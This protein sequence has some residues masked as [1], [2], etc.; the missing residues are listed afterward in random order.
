[1]EWFIKKNATLPT[2]KVKVNKDGR[3]DFE[4]G[5]TDLSESSVFFSM[6]DTETQIPKISSKHGSVISEVNN[7]GETEYYASYQFTKT[8]TNK[9]GRYSAEFMLLNTDGV[10]YLPI[11]EKLFI[12]VTESFS[13][14]DSEFVDNYTIDYS[15]CPETIRPNE[16]I[17]YLSNQDGY[18]LIANQDFL[19][20]TQYI[21]TLNTQ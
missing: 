6:I 14:D 5:D 8:E 20:N 12:N 3:S 4:R 9:E 15:C 11:N 2:L 13:L 19:A 10:I 16:I 7:E 18:R 21:I 1:M 17:K